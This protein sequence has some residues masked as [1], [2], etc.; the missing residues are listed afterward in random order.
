M[1]LR[2]RL[3]T[4]S[5]TSSAECIRFSG[6]ASRRATLLTPSSVPRGSLIGTEPDIQQRPANGL[7]KRKGWWGFGIGRLVILLV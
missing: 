3:K 1:N 5:G 7:G 6:L 4:P 2:G